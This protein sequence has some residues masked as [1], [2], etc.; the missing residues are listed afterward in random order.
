[1]FYNESDLVR[2]RNYSPHYNLI[3]DADDPVRVSAGVYLFK[4]FDLS[5]RLYKRYKG[6]IMGNE[7]TI[8]DYQ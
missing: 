6:V 2:I 1:M 8:E 3:M 7:I 4:A 5:T